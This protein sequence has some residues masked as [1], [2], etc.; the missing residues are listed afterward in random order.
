MKLSVYVPDEIVRA[1]KEAKL[2]I[3]VIC[4]G[5]LRMALERHAEFMARIAEIQAR[6]HD[7]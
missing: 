5:A 6:R 1:A 3:E 4:V 7:E 2:P